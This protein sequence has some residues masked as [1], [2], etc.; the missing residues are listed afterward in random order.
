MGV[1]VVSSLQSQIATGME[2]YSLVGIFIAIALL[3]YLV[4]GRYAKSLEV[5][6]EARSRAGLEMAERLATAIELRDHCTIGHNHRVGQ[7]CQLLAEE[8][9]L[10]QRESRLIYSAAALHDIGKVGIPDE[11]LN[12]NGP[13]TPDERKRIERH[14]EIGAALLSQTDEPLLKMARDI[15]LTHHENW[16]GSGYPYSLKGDE[17]PIAGK[18]AAVA[19]MLDALLSSRPYKIAW[20]FDVAAAE[21][22][23]CAGTKFDPVVVSAFDRALPKLKAIAHEASAAS[24]LEVELNSGPQVL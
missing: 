8:M 15:I 1:A 13:L 14:V 21:I 5:T 19:D 12:K 23:R 24:L 16:D 20:S 10:D 4:I 7:Y 9:G 11:L 2:A 18:I 3:V 17:I 6:Y 22:K